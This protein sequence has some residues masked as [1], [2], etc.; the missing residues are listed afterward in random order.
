MARF[1][2][3]AKSAEGETVTGVLVGESRE[4]VLG[5]LEGDPSVLGSIRAGDEI[6]VE[7]AG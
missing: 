3:R 4:A 6:H 2:Y 7:P 1:R 5:R